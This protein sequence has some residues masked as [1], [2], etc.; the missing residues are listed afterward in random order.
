[1]E[2]GR[3]M[4]LDIGTK[5]TGVAMSDELRLIASPKDTIQEKR[6]DLWFKKVC[7]F[8]E[9]EEVT[10]IVVG[11]PL[12]Q[13]GEEGPD[14]ERIRQYLSMMR[15]RVSIPVIE[16][17]ERFTT[18]QAERLLIGSDVSREKRRTVIDK[19][20]AAIILQSYLDSLK[21]NNQHSDDFVWDNI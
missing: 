9:E 18:L 5:R 14:A 10:S 16:W 7:E 11:L 8:I 3:I 1:M 2:T 20:A 15:K 12:N 17:D 21:S 4:A 6:I 19:I 13:Y